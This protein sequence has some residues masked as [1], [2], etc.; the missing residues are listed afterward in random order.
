MNTRTYL[1]DGIEISE[2]TGLAARRGFGMEIGVRLGS[3]ADDSNRPRSGR[4][5]FDTA[6]NYGMGT[7]EERLGKVFKTLT[8]P[9]W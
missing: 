8:V 6:P 4:Q 3:R 7:S 1:Q 5:L 9:R 2:L